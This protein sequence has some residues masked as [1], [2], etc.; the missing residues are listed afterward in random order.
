MSRAAWVVGIV[1]G[2]LGVSGWIAVVL[3]SAA[4]PGSPALGL[5][6]ALSVAGCA[7]VASST[8][9]GLQAGLLGGAVCA[10]GVFVAVLVLSGA[11]PDSW[12]PPL[13]AVPGM[14]AGVAAE[15]ARIELADPYVWLLPFAVLFGG[16]LFSARRRATRPG[17]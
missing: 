17:R 7:A 16:A 2:L 13:A 10:G 14:S 15:Q 9:D 6:M 4:V 5:V 12:I 8:R 1:L 11:V 3:A